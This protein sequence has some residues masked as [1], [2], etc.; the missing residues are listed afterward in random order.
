MRAK[1][2]AGSIR[3]TV[4]LI[5]VIVLAAQLGGRCF[6]NGEGEGGF[7]YWSITGASFDIENYWTVRIDEL[8]KLGDES[9]KF[10][11]HHTD[12]GFIYQGL[13]DWVDLGF[14]YRHAFRRDGSSGWLQERRPHLNVT[15]K[16]KPGEFDLSDRSRLEY[17]NKEQARDQWRYTNKLMIKL[18]YELTKW[19]L[20]PCFADQV[21]I[22]LDGPAFDRNKVY[23]GFVFEPTGSTAGGLFYV[24][25]SDK[26]DG[27][28]TNTNILWFQLKFHF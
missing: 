11:Y 2:A 9:R 26:T 4:K 1:P 15:V 8:L 23:S 21:Y 25:D 28:W 18:P 5:V 13:A 10:T 16:S 20:R 7:E 3:G 12:L 6:A 27:K 19:K 22:D 17:R 24:W 14:H